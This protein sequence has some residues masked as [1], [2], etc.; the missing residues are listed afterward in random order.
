MIQYL[1]IYPYSVM[2]S[3]FDSFHGGVVL[4]N[5]IMAFGDAERILE[6]ICFYY[7]YLN[8]L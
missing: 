1:Q 3:D 4:N 5:V 8:F 2:Q 6:Q 7:F